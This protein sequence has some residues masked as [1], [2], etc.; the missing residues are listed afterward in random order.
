MKTDK[1]E[2]SPERQR[3]DIEVLAQPQNYNIIAWYEDHG[4]TGTES[5]N[6]PEF[7][8]LLKNAKSGR[9]EA[10]LLSEQSRMSREVI[11]DAMMNWKILRDAGVRIVTC[12]RGE[13]DFSN[14]GGVNEFTTSKDFRQRH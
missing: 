6:R 2:D 11:L 13:L 5:L 1:Q 3:R 7:Q 8:R 12:Q 14:L 4:L 9:F 10:I